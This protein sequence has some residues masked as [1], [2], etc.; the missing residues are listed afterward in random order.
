MLLAFVTAQSIA[1]MATLVLWQ[2]A[3]TKGPAQTPPF[4]SRP[5]PSTFLRVVATVPPGFAALGSSDT[6]NILFQQWPRRSILL[7]NGTWGSVAAEWVSA[8]RSAQFLLKVDATDSLV[9]VPQLLAMLSRIDPARPVYLGCPQRRRSFAAGF[10]YV[11]SHAAAERLSEQ[12]ALLSDERRGALA[13]LPE[14][15]A[16]GALLRRAGVPLTDATPA[17]FDGTPA[18][19]LLAHGTT[20]PCVAMRSAGQN[21]L[22]EL[23]AFKRVLEL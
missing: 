18:Q 2:Q 20:H 15:E 12:L 4:V 23:V 22:H 16:V 5:L 14:N 3:T 7:S 10:A 21:D 17:F 19:R 8:A 13:A 6:R 11:V 9:A 1:I